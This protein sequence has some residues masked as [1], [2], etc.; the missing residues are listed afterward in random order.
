MGIKVAIE[1]KH[2]AR[3]GR[4]R[5]LGWPDYR[6]LFPTGE[7]HEFLSNPIPH[8][9]SSRNLASE[10]GWRRGEHLDQCTK[11]LRTAVATPAEPYTFRMLGADCKMVRPLSGRE[12][13]VS[14]LPD[15]IIQKSGQYDWRCGARLDRDA[16]GSWAQKAQALRAT[17]PAA[18]KA[19]AREIIE[20][21]RAREKVGYPPTISADAHL[22]YLLMA[23]RSREIPF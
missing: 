16:A 10:Q 3:A 15:R 8:S 4:F 9:E 21:Q 14:A 11:A 6:S 20:F 13:Q 1:G 23:R 17:T 12:L 5:F 22:G 19:S 7:S 2:V 18:R